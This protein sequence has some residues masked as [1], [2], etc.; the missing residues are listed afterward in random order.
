MDEYMLRLVKLS[1][2]VSENSNA[3]D[4]EFR[5]LINAARED[6]IRLNI[7]DDTSKKLIQQAIVLYVKGNW[8]NTKIDEK[9]LSLQRYDSLCNNLRLSSEY[10]G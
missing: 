8:G 9:E 7:K 2:S 4:E 3:K 10:R 1:C 6:L 5:L